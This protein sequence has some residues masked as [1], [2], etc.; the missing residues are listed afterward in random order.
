MV[1]Q[2]G[3]FLIKIYAGFMAQAKR[4]SARPVRSTNRDVVSPYI[5]RDGAL[6]AVDEMTLYNL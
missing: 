5:R 6:F 2:S 3:L 1:T 4:C